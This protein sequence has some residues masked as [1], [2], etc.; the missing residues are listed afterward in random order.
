[1]LRSEGGEAEASRPGRANKT[2]PR[3]RR[4]PPR[5]I[6]TPG[7]FSDIHRPPT[8]GPKTIKEA[9][10]GPPGPF[11]GPG[12]TT[13]W[14]PRPDGRWAPYRIKLP[15]L[16]CECGR[17]FSTEEARLNHLRTDHGKYEES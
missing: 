11:D 12:T 13:G 3:T 15:V 7:D 2:I 16:T 8:Q 17:L 5:T 9:L 14:L 4:I 6:T 1:M 10:L